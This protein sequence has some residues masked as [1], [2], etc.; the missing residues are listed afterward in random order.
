MG[1][2]HIKTTIFCC[3]F[4]NAT[5]SKTK[6]NSCTKKLPPPFFQFQCIYKIVS[7]LRTRD[8]RKAYKC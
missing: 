3:C 2:F 4:N 8:P 6:G 7:D 1:E 5:I